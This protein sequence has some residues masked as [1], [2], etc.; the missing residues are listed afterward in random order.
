MEVLKK[1]E[2]KYGKEGAL[3]V[4]VQEEVG[5]VEEVERGCIHTFYFCLFRRECL[6]LFYL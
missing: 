4:E 2:L 5:V 1:D 6:F 3:L